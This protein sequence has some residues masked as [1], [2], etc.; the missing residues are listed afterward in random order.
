M[1]K[2]VLKKILIENFKGIEKLVINFNENENFII[3]AN[4]TG[5]TRIKD[6]YDWVL[7]NNI[8]NIDTIGS[9]KNASVLI[10]FEG[11]TLYRSTNGEN[12]IDGEIF[13]TNE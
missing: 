12:K 5:K 1:K 4:G 8:N 13:K 3:G 7:F 6:A 2:F 11:F 9:N 10:E